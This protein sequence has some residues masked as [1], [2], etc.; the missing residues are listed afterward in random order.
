MAFALAGRVDID[1]VKEP[2][3][4]GKNGKEIFLKD[5]WPSL[6]EIRDALRSALTPEMFTSLYGNFAG[7]N[8]KWNEISAPTGEIY[9]WDTRSTYIQE[10]PFFENF[11]MEAGKITPISGPALS[12]SSATL[13]RPIT[14]PRPEPSRRNPQQ[15]AS[16]ASM[17][18]PT[19]TSTA[20]VVAA[21]MTAS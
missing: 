19:K 10:P 11:G 9:E 2:I 7:Q 12:A 18:S 16:S 6:S 13:S 15:A 1:F 17:E 8:P 3:G 21:A 5:I 14:S 4:L 20:T